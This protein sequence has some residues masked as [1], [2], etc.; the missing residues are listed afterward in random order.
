MSERQEKWKELQDGINKVIADWRKR[1]PTATL[2]EIEDIVDIQLAPLRAQMVEDLAG[3]GQTADLGQ[4]EGDARPR[5]PQCGMPVV[6]NGKQKRRLVTRQEQGIELER[7][8]AY[9]RHC[10]VSFFPSG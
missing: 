8:K 6:A 4:L 5:C 1:H 3:E 7:S 2:S 10:K 9:C